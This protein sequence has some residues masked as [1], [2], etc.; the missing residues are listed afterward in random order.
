VVTR[1]QLI[2]GSGRRAWWNSIPAQQRDA[3]AADR[4]GR[5]R[6]HPRYIET[7][8]RKGY[9]FIGKLD[10]HTPMRGIPTCRRIRPH[11]LRNRRRDRPPRLGSARTA[12]AAGLGVRQLLWRLVLSVVVWKMPAGCSRRGTADSLPTIV[13]LPSST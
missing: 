2:A 8:P 4:A 6:G 11:L 3:Q 1:E 5:R 13:V 7:L 9:R 10:D 12:E